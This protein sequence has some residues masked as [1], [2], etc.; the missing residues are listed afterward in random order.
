MAGRMARRS[1]FLIGRDGVVRARWIGEDSTV[2]PTERL[3][4]AA[5]TLTTG[6]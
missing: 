5:R 4:E 3:L 6:R 2:F 1:F